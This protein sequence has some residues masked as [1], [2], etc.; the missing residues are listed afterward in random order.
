M[1]TNIKIRYP[2]NKPGY[3]TRA[4]QSI[5]QY[6]VG[7]MVDFP[8]QTLMTA[9]PEAWAQSVTFI[10]D[11]RLANSLDVDCFGMPG[12]VAR[13]S[14]TRLGIS[15]VRF[16]EWYF[17]PVCRRFMPFKKWEEEYR[18]LRG[19][20]DNERINKSPKCIVCKNCD[21]VAANII[22]VCENGHINDFPWVEWAHIKSIPSKPICS[23]P[24][25]KFRTNA[26]LNEGMQGY[27]VECDSC[28]AS[29]SL[30]DAFSPLVFSDLINEKGRTEFCCQGRHPWN[31]TRKQCPQIPVAKRRGDSSVYFSCSVS[32]IVI[33]SHSDE[34]TN[35]IKEC[36]EYKKIMT[37]L[38]DCDDEEERLEKIDKRIDKWIEAVAK[39]LT[40]GK[41]VVS[42]TLRKLL[43]ENANTSAIHPVDSSEYRYEEYEALAG[44]NGCEIRGS[45]DFLREETNIDEYKL[46]GV[47]KIVLVKKLREVR[48][49]VGFSRL[50]PVKY[51]DR[52][53][54][55]FVSIKEKDTRWYPGYEVRGEGIFIQFDEQILKEWA[56]RE[57]IIRR[58]ENMS[59]NY[60]E[61]HLARRFGKNPDAEFVFLH[62]LAHLLLKQLSFE[63]GYNIA[64]LRE[65]IYYKDALDDN[66]MAGILIYTASGDSE[67]TLGGLVRQG[68]SDCFSRIFREAIDK[69]R[70]C[71]N[72]PVCI[73]SSG[74]GLE[75]LNLAACHSCCL[76]PETS[77]ENF[78]V[79]LD[80]ALV[81]GTFEDP[82]LGFYS[83]NKKGKNRVETENTSTKGPSIVSEKK[84][85]VLDSGL[86]QTGTY[87]EIWEYIKDDTD[88]EEEQEMFD[89]LI[90]ASTGKYEKPVYGGKV[91]VDGEEVSVDLL[92]KEAQVMFFLSENIDNF[93]K[94]QG[95]GWNTFCNI[96]EKINIETLLR[97]IEEK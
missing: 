41:L 51:E 56:Q 59:D 63:C 79:F 52:D 70:M 14:N 89:A 29:A 26:G 49:L 39:E 31:G 22:T 7:A 8:D 13:N 47:K 24:K 48:A 67:G 6:G 43:L 33:P 2:I 55:G 5:L 44:I 42:K 83:S 86:I 21:L 92:W 38:D 17:C 15:Y 94:M 50:Q 28:K 34:E 72:D 69:A 61:A 97:E 75:S 46:D 36:N 19:T 54:A 68:R 96:A 73:T 40:I 45:E 4:S 77:C 84:I 90:K 87:T 58:R 20:E 35:R 95:G 66:S 18:R 23:N 53:K 81:V 57:E 64:S 9:K 32:S 60:R 76:V 12:T 10:E 16:P 74:Q 27:I 25:L 82:E 1:S 88:D 65:R 80:R 3:S 11:K 37:I 85:E 91:L 62:T 93:K 30:R 78:N 71:S